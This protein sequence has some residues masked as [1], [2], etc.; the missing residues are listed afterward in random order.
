MHGE[1][2]AHALRPEFV[3][4]IG[5]ARDGIFAR[6][7]RREEMADVIRHLHQMLRAAVCFAAVRGGARIAIHGRSYLATNRTSALFN[8]VSWLSLNS[9]KRFCHSDGW[10]TRV[11]CTAVTLYSGQFVAQ[12]E[13]S[14]VI[15]FAPDS[16]KW[17][18][19]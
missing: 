19:V 4:V 8:N 15:T 12:S 17:N 7:L 2:R 11:A 10:L 1:F 14:V 18:V 3:D 13:L 6:G 5:D 16:G 9:R